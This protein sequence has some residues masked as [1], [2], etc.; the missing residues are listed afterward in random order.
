MIHTS[1]AQFEENEDDEIEYDCDAY[2]DDPVQEVVPGKAV[3][4]TVV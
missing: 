4:S 3:K 1:N 2:S